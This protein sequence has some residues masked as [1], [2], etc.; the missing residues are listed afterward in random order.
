ME[1]KDYDEATASFVR[2]L[3]MFK[4]QLQTLSLAASKGQAGAAEEEKPISELVKP[5]IFDT[6]EMKRVKGLMIEVQEYIN[7]IDYV[8]KNS[9]EI[10]KQRAEA[11]EQ[12]KKA[13]GDNVP[14]GFG[15]PQPDAEKFQTATFTLKPKKRTFT[16]MK[17]AYPADETAKAD[18][19][20]AK[21]PKL[22]Q[23]IENGEKG[24]A[25]A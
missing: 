8:K 5:S 24:A 19:E 15:K 7:E 1:L 3:D 23:P 18:D 12:A 6:E 16:E 22:E 10:E 13:S 11:Q 14:E 21:R 2:V 17:A 20:G 25:V 4:K 9:V